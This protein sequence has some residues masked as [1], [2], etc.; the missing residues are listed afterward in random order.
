RLLTESFPFE[1]SEYPRNDRVA[2]VF[3]AQAAATPDAIAIRSASGS[4]TYRELN[5][6]ANGLARV[7]RERG[8]RPEE[9]IGVSMPPSEFIPVALLGI[10]KAGAAY[11][12]LDIAVP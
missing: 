3:E 1:R 11:L 2:C 9:L 12:P 8:V 10:L 7:L 6:R 5:A 4:L